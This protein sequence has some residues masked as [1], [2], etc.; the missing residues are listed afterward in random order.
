MVG[1][2]D[3]CQ[4]P[5]DWPLH[6][7]FSSLRSGC[8]CKGCCREQ[9]VH[10]EKGREWKGMDCHEPRVGLGGCRQL[11]KSYTQFGNGGTRHPDV[12]LISSHLHVCRKQER[13]GK[14]L[15]VT[16]DCAIPVVRAQRDLALWQTLA[17]KVTWRAQN[18]W[19]F[20]P[21]T[22]RRCSTH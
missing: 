12:R 8:V 22:P 9:L 15:S 11:K 1:T 21:E 14:P 4:I 7:Y 2:A 5:R 18:Q 3:C 19:L 17:A 6:S 16:K 10:T 13:L 20:P